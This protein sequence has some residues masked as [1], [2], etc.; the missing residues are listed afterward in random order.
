M[1]DI[2]GPRVLMLAQ[3]EAYCTRGSGKIIQL[4]IAEK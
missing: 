2:K 4:E 1:I 3:T